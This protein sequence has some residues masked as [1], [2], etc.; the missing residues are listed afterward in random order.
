MIFPAELV[1]PHIPPAPLKI[2]RVPSAAPKELVQP[3]NFPFFPG[4]VSSAGQSE[5][6]GVNGREREGIMLDF[7][8]DELDDEG[9]YNDAKKIA[10]NVSWLLELPFKNIWQRR[11]GRRV[12]TRPYKNMLPGATH[13]RRGQMYNIGPYRGL[14]DRDHGN[15]KVL[16][17]I[18][19][20][21]SNGQGKSDG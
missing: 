11:S 20:G 13:C 4:Q 19:Q 7:G 9:D 21:E 12:D 17:D 10:E 15:S 8:P 2:T 3:R 5:D 16:N 1:K 14:N 18:G 6:D